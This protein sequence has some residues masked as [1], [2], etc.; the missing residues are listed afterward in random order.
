MEEREGG[1]GGPLYLSTSILNGII[2]CQ[3][4]SCGDNSNDKNHILTESF[5]NLFH[6]SYRVVS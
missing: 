4:N 6:M 3:D 2:G 5:Y 1:G